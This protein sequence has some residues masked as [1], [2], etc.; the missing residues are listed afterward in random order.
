[1]SLLSAE[2][3][4]TGY[5]GM[6]VLWEVD[7]AVEPGELLCVLGP[8][9]AGKTSLAMCI[10]GVLPAWSGSLAFD[11]LDVTRANPERRAGLGIIQVL[12][13]R[14]VFPDLSVDENLR[15]ARFAARTRASAATEQF[16]FE[17]FEPLTRLR[18][19]PAGRLSGGEQQMVAIARALFAEPR[20]LIL[21]EPSLGLAPLL[22][23]GLY[24][25]IRRIKET[26]VSVLLIEQ[27]VGAALE[28]A[29][30][31][32]VL[33]AGR[34][35]DGGPVEKFRDSAVLA[36]GYLGGHFGGANDG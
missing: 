9:G 30:R 27:V 36:H 26:G 6:R 12:Q 35:V 7:L 23:Q 13:G 22:V 14:R 28:V 17:L 5:G 16:V 21:D 25:A 32:A 24:R 15:V 33:E 18:G 3:I 2:G 31:V 10:S 20:L 1:M 19:V 4:S 29:D 34:I 8:N 11:G